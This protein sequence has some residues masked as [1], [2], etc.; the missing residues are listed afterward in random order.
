MRKTVLLLGM[1][2]IASSAMMGQVVNRNMA[3]AITSENAELVLDSVVTKTRE[4]K[5]SAKVVY[6]YDSEKRKAYEVSISYSECLLRLM[7][8]HME[9]RLNIRMT[10][11]VFC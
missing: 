7:H 4:G 5:P 3:A 1:A 2:L 6:G 11:Q 9:I 8:L 10:K